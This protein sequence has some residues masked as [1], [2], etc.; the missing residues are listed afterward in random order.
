[1]ARAASSGRRI[2]S[3]PGSNFSNSRCRPLAPR[4]PTPTRAPRHPRSRWGLGCM[5]EDRLG[6]SHADRGWR[7][8]L[9]HHLQQ[10]GGCRCGSLLESCDGLTVR[11]PFARSVRCIELALLHPLQQCVGRNTNAFRG[12]LDVALGKQRGDRFVFLAPNFVP[13][14]RIYRNLTQSDA[15]WRSPATIAFLSPKPQN[16]LALSR[17][18]SD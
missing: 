8:G 6:S 14:P 11:G 15:I 5:I 7:A 4:A 17:G 18:Q 13:C 2:Y 3:L 16:P 12:L 10:R 9:Y 1:M